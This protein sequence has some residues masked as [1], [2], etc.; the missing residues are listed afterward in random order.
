MASLLSPQ[1]KRLLSYVR[2]YSFRL[3]IGVVLVAFVAL[4]EGLVAF[5]ARIAWDFV[6]TPTAPSSQLPLFT[7]PG[8][9]TIY[10]N[11]FFP[12]RIHN[13]WTIFSLALVVLFVSKGIAEYF[14]ITEIQYAGHAAITNLRNQVSDPVGTAIWS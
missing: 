6:L 12:A 13:V 14:G 11:E 4:A 9:R 10:L 3:S 2:P 5:M 8:G 1:F 7:I